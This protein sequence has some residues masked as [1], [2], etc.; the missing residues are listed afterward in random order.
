MNL[1]C[2]LKLKENKIFCQSNQEFH[3]K[4]S[5]PCGS[6]QCIKLFKLDFAGQNINFISG[7]NT[8]NAFM[9][10]LEMDIFKFKKDIQ[11]S[12]LNYRVRHIYGSTFYQGSQEKLLK[13][14]IYCI[15][16]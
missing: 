16:L 4:L 10:K 15:E 3:L 5:K 6:F 13:S 7:Y 2:F 9:A 12:F 1:F 14:N 8:I 11:L